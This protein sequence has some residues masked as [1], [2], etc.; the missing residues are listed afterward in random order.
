MIT[1][2]QICLY[3][4]KENGCLKPEWD[5]CPMTN[6]VRPRKRIT[7]ADRI[8]AMSDDDM[9]KWLA[10][11]FDCHSCSEHKRLGDNPLLSDEQCDQEC[12]KHCLDWLKQPYEDGDGK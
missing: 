12:E 11:M 5:E 10:D 4:F 7:N 9:A 1:C 8:R 2:N 3:N 6:T